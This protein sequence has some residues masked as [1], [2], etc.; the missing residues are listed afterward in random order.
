MIRK[1]TAIGCLL[2]LSGCAIAHPTEATPEVDGT[3]ALTE[4]GTEPSPRM[5]ETCSFRRGW[6]DDG[7]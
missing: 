5:E 3:W 4:Y 1:R 7:R 6:W 2:A